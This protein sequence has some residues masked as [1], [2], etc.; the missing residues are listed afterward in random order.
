MSADKKAL[1]VFSSVPVPVA[2]VKNVLPAI[3]AMVMVLIYNLAAG[4]E[5]ILSSRQ[6]CHI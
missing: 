4:S 2:V 3:G 5:D 6:V 1:E